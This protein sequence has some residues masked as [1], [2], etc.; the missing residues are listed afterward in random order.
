VEQILARLLVEMDAMQEKMEPK[1]YTSQEEKML[2][3]IDAN[4]EKMDAKIDTNQ[5]RLEAKKR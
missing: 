1:I 4:Q 3:N 2:A 5:E